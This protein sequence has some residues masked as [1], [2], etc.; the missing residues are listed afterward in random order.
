VASRPSGC[1]S[2]GCGG[3]GPGKFLARPSET[4]AQTRAEAEEDVYGLQ[5]GVSKLRY[6]PHNA[7]HRHDAL[8]RGH[9]ASCTLLMLHAN[10]HAPRTHHAG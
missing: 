7:E 1:C 6:S 10:T 9:A 4:I 8:E 5:R 3:Y 2:S